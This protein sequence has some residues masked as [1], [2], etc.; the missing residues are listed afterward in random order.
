MPDTTYI[1]GD[2]R[3]ASAYYTFNGEGWNGRG[4]V[5]V[6]DHGTNQRFR[7]QMDAIPN[8]FLFTANAYEGAG[9][10]VYEF[11]CAP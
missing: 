5:D 7:A 4:W 8:G 9:S 3:S 11:H 1:S 10:T 2:I 6:V